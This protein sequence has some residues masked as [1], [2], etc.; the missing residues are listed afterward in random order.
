MKDAP[1]REPLIVYAVVAAIASIPVI[2]AV[3]RGG[4]FGT[5]ATVGVLMLAIALAGLLAMRWI[6]H[7][8]R[9]RR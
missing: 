4:R 3:A 8:R 2:V 9:R 1:N 7:E 5:E 6:A